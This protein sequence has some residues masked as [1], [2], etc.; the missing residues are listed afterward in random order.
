MNALMNI[1]KNSQKF[2]FNNWKIKVIRNV[3]C[4]NGREKGYTVIWYFQQLVKF[5]DI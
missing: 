3:Q 1:R 2:F 4:G 5:A